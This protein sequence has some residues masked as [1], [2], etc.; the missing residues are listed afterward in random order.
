MS[1]EKENT[2]NVVVKGDGLGCCCCL[3]LALPPTIATLCV[4]LLIIKAI[5]GG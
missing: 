1:E 2:V 3:A 4:V 5:K